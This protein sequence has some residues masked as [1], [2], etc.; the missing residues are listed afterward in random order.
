MMAVAV[1][2]VGQLDALRHEI[3]GSSKSK[4]ELQWQDRA[5]KLS[6]GKLSIQFQLRLGPSWL[7]ITVSSGP[8]SVRGCGISSVSGRGGGESLPSFCQ[9][10]LDV[11]TTPAHQAIKQK[12]WPIAKL[13]SDGATEYLHCLTR[14]PSS[15]TQGGPGGSTVPYVECTRLAVAQCLAVAARSFSAPRNTGWSL[16]PDRAGMPCV[17]ESLRVLNT[18]GVGAGHVCLLVG[19]VGKQASNWLDIGYGMEYGGSRYHLR[20]EE[21]GYPFTLALYWSGSGPKFVG[22][23]VWVGTKADSIENVLPYA[24]PY[25][26]PK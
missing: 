15:L 1:G 16:M 17:R 13:C 6:A 3:S 23:P 26:Y 18:A 10:A 8:V 4:D 20:G 12:K 9:P 25:P 7:P 24:S 22:M 5:G 2:S 14:A 21:G 11:G 19:L